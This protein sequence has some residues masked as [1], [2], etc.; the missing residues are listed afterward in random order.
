[1]GVRAACQGIGVTP[2]MEG[3]RS[4]PVAR[5]RPG[6]TSVG[7]AHDRGT[8]TTLAIAWQMA[9]NVA[10]R[11]CGRSVLRGRIRD[12]LG[13]CRSRSRRAPRGGTAA[14]GTVLVLACL[15]DADQRGRVP[16]EILNPRPCRKTA[17]GARAHRPHE[18]ARSPAEH[19]T[20]QDVAGVP[21]DELWEA[22]PVAALHRW[23]SW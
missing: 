6:G 11:P 13:S 9:S 22:D 2:M 8:G 18:G 5:Y 14:R 17:G 12:C 1:M 23:S 10:P 16:E 15:A 19:S 4:I 20:R 3:A 7:R 21:L